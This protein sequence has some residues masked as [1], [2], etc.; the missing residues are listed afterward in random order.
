MALSPPE[1]AWGRLIGPGEVSVHQERLYRLAVDAISITAVYR[2]GRGWELA[3]RARRGDET[4][5]EAHRGDY[6]LLVS[7]ELCQVICSE[8]DN[9]L[10]L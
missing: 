4:W 6:E 10:G 7:S 8:L 5:A 3:L 2:P 9:V 1:A